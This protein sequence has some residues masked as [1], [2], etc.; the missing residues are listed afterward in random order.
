MS[1][2]ERESQRY[3]YTIRLIEIERKRLNGENGFV[4]KNY[5]AHSQ[6]IL[7]IFQI[8]IPCDALDSI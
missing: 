6:P 8:N 4:R 7:I 2:S 3:G 1:S 5:F